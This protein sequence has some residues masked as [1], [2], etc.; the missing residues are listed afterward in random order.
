M[1]TLTKEIRDFDVEDFDFVR[2]DDVVRSLLLIRLGTQRL[3]KV[4]YF[5]SWDSTLAASYLF[6]WAFVCFFGQVIAQRLDTQNILGST[7]SSRG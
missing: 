6:V 5:R 3:S 7:P 1:I 2:V 4:I